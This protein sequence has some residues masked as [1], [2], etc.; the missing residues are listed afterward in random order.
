M[1]VTRALE[2]I[3]EVLALLRSEWRVRILSG[4]D[5]I[6]YGVN[7]GFEV[8]YRG[9]HLC[10]T[11]SRSPKPPRELSRAEARALGATPCTSSSDTRCPFLPITVSDWSV[12]EDF[13]LLSSSEI[14]P[15]ST[16]CGTLNVKILSL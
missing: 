1:F 12:V 3:H 5:D 7:R 16:V 8:S 11:I 4:H 15:T 6:W 14:A 13:N 9:T 2:Q 10:D